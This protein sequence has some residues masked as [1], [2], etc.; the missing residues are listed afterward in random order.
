MID[1]APQIYKDMCDYL[2]PYVDK[3]DGVP[4]PFKTLEYLN[5]RRDALSN[6]FCRAEDTAGQHLTWLQYHYLM[7]RESSLVDMVA[8][9]TLYKELGDDLDI[10]IEVF[11]CLEISMS[12]DPMKPII[13]PLGLKAPLH[14]NKTTP[15]YVALALKFAEEKD[16]D[17]TE[18]YP[19]IL[20]LEMEDVNI[21]ND[22]LYNMTGMEMNVL[23]ELMSSAKGLEV[24]L[25]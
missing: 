25:A 21:I 9:E 7:S 18:M 14:D 12:A 1:D 16:W 24:W 8:W 6:A 2:A 13:T 22:Y 4:I 17:I 23:N 3:L 19:P 5:T 10:P 11:E 20:G 15:T